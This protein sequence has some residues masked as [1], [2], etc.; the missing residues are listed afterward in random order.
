[1]SVT[2]APADG[3]ALKAATWDRRAGSHGDKD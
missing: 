1:M 2:L 3:D